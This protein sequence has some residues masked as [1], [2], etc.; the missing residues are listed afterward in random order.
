MAHNT[1]KSYTKENYLKTLYHLTSAK[2]EVTIN[3]LAQDLGLKMPSVTSMVQKL[4]N[5]KLIRYEKY[6]PVHLTEKGKKEAGLI[7][8]KHRLTEMF[9]VEKMQFGWEEVHDI[10]EQLEHLESEPFF[11]KIDEMLGYP[12][13]DPHGSPIPDLHGKMRSITRIPLSEVPDGK[14]VRL[15]GL[16]QSGDD[17][18]KFLNTKK[19]KLGVS[20]K[21]IKKEAFDGS[22]KLSINKDE[23]SLSEIV[24]KQLLVV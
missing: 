17:F 12:S 4:A 13:I 6:K 1:V 3:E 14:T 11:R 10:A 18:L 21:V 20:I 22:M 7:I 8:R 15:T 5:E 19:I 2:G 23:L 16:T 9:L 24:C